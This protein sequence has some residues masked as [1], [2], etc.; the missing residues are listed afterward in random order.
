MTLWQSTCPWVNVPERGGRS[1]TLLD[2]ATHTSGL[3]RLPTNM[4][5]GNAAHPYADYSVEQLY[6]FLAK[7]QPTPDIGSQYAYPDLGSGLRLTPKMPI[8]ICL[9]GVVHTDASGVAAA[10]PGDCSGLCRLWHQSMA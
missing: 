3:P 6:N 5:P 9:A 10:R 8:G 4:H 2:L 1:I 7:Y